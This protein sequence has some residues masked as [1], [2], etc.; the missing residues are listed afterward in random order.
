MGRLDEKIL[1]RNLTLL[2]F[3][4]KLAVNDVSFVKT[5]NFFNI[6]CLGGLKSENPCNPIRRSTYMGAGERT[7]KTP[8]RF[9][10][11]QFTIIINTS[12][13]QHW[14]KHCSIYIGGGGRSVYEGCNSWRLRRV[15]GEEW[16][17]REK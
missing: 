3:Q 16:N 2:S 14:K 5:Y 1:L 17:G 12:H 6:Q 15:R 4:E 11:L 10:Q 8:T 9:S 13:S 7:I